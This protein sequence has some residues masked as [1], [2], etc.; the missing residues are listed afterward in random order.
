MERGLLSAPFLAIRS[1]YDLLY[2]FTIDNVA[3]IWNPL[4]GSAVA[5]ALMCLLS[6]FIILMIFIYL[7]FKQ[8]RYHQC[9]RQ[10]R[11]RSWHTD[12]QAEQV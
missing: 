9:R 1:T 6:E 8:L 2:E 12:R 3:S 5:F 10:Q 11:A 4:V 7:G